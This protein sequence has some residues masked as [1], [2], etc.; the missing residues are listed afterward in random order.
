M[1]GKSTQQGRRAITQEQFTHLC[2]LLQQVKTGQQGDQISEAIASVNCAGI[3]KTITTT[4]FNCLS[5]FSYFYPQ[6]WIIDLGGTEHMT[7]DYLVLFDIQTL[8]MDLY[9]YPPNSQRVKVSQ[10]GHVHILHG[11]TITNVLF[12]PEFR[13]NLL[14]V[15]KITKQLSSNL[16]FSS[17]DV[18]LQ[19]PSMKRPVI[20][21]KIRNENYLLNPTSSLNF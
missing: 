11:L 21:G 9:I 5:F 6:S 10:V 16:I 1:E 2:Q 18:T 14:S 15:H 7:Y 8:S 17:I 13:L 12:V 20:V 4:D 19:G 3:P